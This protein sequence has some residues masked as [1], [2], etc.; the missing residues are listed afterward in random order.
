MKSG[1]KRLAMFSALTSYL[2]KGSP[3]FSC[4]VVNL[5]FK[6]YH[7][8]HAT[9]MKVYHS[10]VTKEKKVSRKTWFFRSH[11]SF[12]QRDMLVDLSSLRTQKVRF[13]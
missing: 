2:S 3:E 12:L 8:W 10:D 11:F 13:F 6:A 5:L 7:T 1:K 4:C 9:H